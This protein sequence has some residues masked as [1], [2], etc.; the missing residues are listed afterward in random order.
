MKPAIKDLL[1]SLRALLRGNTISREVEEELRFHVEMTTE[2]NLRAGMSAEAARQNALQRFGSFEKFRRI[3]RDVRGA[4][5]L[6]TF[7]Q[8]LH[9]GA[10]IL[11]KSKIVTLAVVATLAIGIG[12]NS[13]VFTV[14]HAVFLRPLPYPHA[15]RLVFVT[16]QLPLLNN[17]VVAAADFLDWAKQKQVFEELTA[18]A[19]GS[20]NL[21]GGD[22]PELVQTARVSSDFFP[23]LRLSP[24]AGRPFVPEDDSPNSRR[25]VL[26][27]YEMWQQ[28]F[29]GDQAI[30]GRAITLN[31]QPYTVVGVMPPR[32]NFFGRHDMWIPLALDPVREMQRQRMQIVYCIGRLQ[33][34]ITLERARADL[35]AVAQRTAQAHGGAY[36]GVSIRVMPLQER[37]VGNSRSGLLLLW[38]AVGFILLIACANV[39]NLLLARG[40][41]REKEMV[42][43][44]VMGAPRIRLVRQLLTES[45]LLSTA[46]GI[47]GLVIARWGAD[48]LRSFL[49]T[50]AADVRLKPDVTVLVFT[51]AISI[52]TGLLFGIMPAVAASRATPIPI[53]RGASNEARSFK[54]LRL[55]DVLVTSELALTLVLL[56]SAGLLIKSFVRFR[57]VNTGFNSQNAWTAALQMPPTPADQTDKQSV[58]LEA[59]L[60]RVRRLP[61][62]TAA[63]FVDHLPLS[64][65][66]SDLAIVSAEG[67]PPWPPQDG[68]KHLI[69]HRI[70][71]DGYLRALG[72]PI[73][74]GRDFSV[75]DIETSTGNVI[76]SESLARRF[77]A[78]TDPVGHRLKLGFV[79]SP[80]PWLTIVGVAGD[81]HESLD[82]EAEPAIYS[83]RTENASLRSEYLVVRTATPD[84]ALLPSVRAEVASLNG[85]V[86][87]Y[88]PASMQQRVDEASA[89]RRT[90]ALLFAVFAGIAILL[91][92]VGTYGV[93]AYSVSLRSREI[94]IRMA[95]GAQASHVLWLVMQTVTL[96]VLSGIGLG[97]IGA[98]ALTR[99]LAS[100]LY[101]VTPT[102]AWVF[103]GVSIL[104]CGVAILAGYLPAHRAARLDPLSVLKYE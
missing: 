100:T 36:Q 77:F 12:A 43:R 97:L 61:G 87:I 33:P 22:Q 1:A 64:S 38:V 5:A 29:H 60:D 52:F 99:F 10:R 16:Q 13:T 20:M 104:L 9:F 27:G 15:E 11:G 70:I 90:R 67:E 69:P 6:E 71:S 4:G 3:C 50:T 53:L 96:T 93:V 58:F 41:G 95:L 91:A 44:A 65:G 30:L 35:M 54:G 84:S 103:A 101:A 14:I 24:I 21:T 75:Q 46:G 81:V 26:I 79:E 49:P 63:G 78:G 39:A 57:Q 74:R 42:I 56:V 37:F 7:F 40:A 51:L 23:M 66:G 48:S 98:H 72:V 80:A 55:R 47:A 62:V 82:R 18:F 94:A 45:L 89:S 34:G 31:D 17:E 73:K 88:D 85:N 83:P 68:I 86:P 32:F 8:D 92:C 25:V 28:H 76:I 2:E 102:D 19:S 59:I